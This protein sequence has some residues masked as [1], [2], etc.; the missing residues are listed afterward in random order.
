MPPEI[1]CIQS[2]GRDPK[3]SFSEVIL[4]TKAHFLPVSIHTGV[5]HMTQENGMSAM[6]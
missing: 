5:N 6:E 3:I 2:N 4:S 1:S